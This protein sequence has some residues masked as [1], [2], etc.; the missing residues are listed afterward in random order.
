MKV[1]FIGGGNMALSILNGLK[2]KNFIMADISIAEVDSKKR[3]EISELYKIKVSEKLLSI[4]SESVVILAVKPD[5]LSIV[6]SEI[7]E[8]I[9]DQLIISI[10]AGTRIKEI[11]KFLGSYNNVIRAMP[12]LCASIKKSVTP[13]FTNNPLSNSQV[14]MIESILGSTGICFSVDTEEKLDAVTALSGS[15][16][17]YIFYIIKSLINAG[18]NLGLSREESQ[19]LIQH[20]VVGAELFSR[21][22]SDDGLESLITKVS[23]KGGTTEQAINVF[24]NRRINEIIEEAVTAAH[25]RSK[26]IGGD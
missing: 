16:P 6:C 11:S 2:D 23:S 9:K 17:A 24:K 15:G 18:E 21:G 13:Y 12:N 14:G 22:L 3:N 25:K 5:Q 8:L 19:K 10:A 4:D 26:E 7:K 20:T 1:Y